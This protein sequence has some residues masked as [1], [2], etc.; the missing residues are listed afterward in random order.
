MMSE[1]EQ[2][3]LEALSALWCARMMAWHALVRAEQDTALLAPHLHAADILV[4]VVSCP[5]CR[6]ERTLVV[7]AQE[8]LRAYGEPRMEA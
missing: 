7:A 4:D 6:A 3:R 8:R 5:R 2:G 1:S